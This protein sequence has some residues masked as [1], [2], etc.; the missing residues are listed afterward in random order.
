VAV[1]S[2]LP[3]GVRFIS[4]QP[5]QGICQQTPRVLCRLDLLPA[6]ASADITVTGSVQA[7]SG[8]IT[9]RATVSSPDIVGDDPENNS[10]MTSAAALPAEI[11]DVPTLGVWMLCALAAL[12][13]FIA[14]LKL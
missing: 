13:A 3:P 5:A 10:S 14:V 11:D 2:P 1:E 8:T 4:A 9:T 7:A 6:G 12:L